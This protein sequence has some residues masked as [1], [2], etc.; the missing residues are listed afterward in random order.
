MQQVV[1][2]YLL[3]VAEHRLLSYTAQ[4][5]WHIPSSRQIIQNQAHIDAAIPG[6]PQALL[7]RKHEQVSMV[8]H[9][10]DGDARATHHTFL[11]KSGDMRRNLVRNGSKIQ[12]RN[13]YHCRERNW[14]GS[15]AAIAANTH[16]DLETH[17]FLGEGYKVPAVFYAHH[18]R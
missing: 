1:V 10:T 3:R 15:H 9:R 2:R 6:N 17:L 18:N 7:E 13:V 14:T 12:I 4:Q 11:G 8:I 5:E 16:I